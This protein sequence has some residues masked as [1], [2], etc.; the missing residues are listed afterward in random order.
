MKAADNQT[1]ETTNNLSPFQLSNIKYV[2]IDT[3]C[4]Q[5]HRWVVAGDFMHCFKFLNNL[6]AYITS[7]MIE[8]ESY[9]DDRK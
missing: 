6:Y 2:F 3:V 4:K 8:Q 7:Y 1:L 9:L 5:T